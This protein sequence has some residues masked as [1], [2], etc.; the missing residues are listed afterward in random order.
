MADFTP[1]SD[2]NETS[3][4]RSSA[5]QNQL[6]TAPAKEVVVL[7]GLTRDV[8]DGNNYREVRVEYTAARKPL[9]QRRAYRTLRYASTWH[10]ALCAREGRCSAWP[11]PAGGGRMKKSHQKY[12]NKGCAHVAR[13]IAGRCGMRETATMGE[14]AATETMD[15]I[16]PSVPRAFR[17]RTTARFCSARRRPAGPAAS[18]LL[19]RLILFVGTHYVFLFV[20]IVVVRS[21]E[22]PQTTRLLFL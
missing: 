1:I 4:W 14:T 12:K 13:P 21:P 7:L 5:A 11:F 16:S 8:S 6:Y 19:Y 15:R 17:R 3:H 20:F 2:F 22:I 10:V 9:M 18:I